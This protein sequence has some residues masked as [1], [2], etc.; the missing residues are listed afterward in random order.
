[1]INLLDVESALTEVGYRSRI[2]KF[3][4]TTLLFEDDSILGFV[5][6]F[7]TVEQLLENWKLKQNQFVS[8]MTVEL[9]RSATKS[10]NC[11][12]VFLTREEVDTHQR[13][14]L[15]DIEEDLS[16]TRKLVGDGLLTT[17]DIR[18]VLLPILPIQ[19][20][21]SSTHLGSQ[22]LS[23]RLQAWPRAALSALEGDGTPIDLVE[24]LF[25]DQ[26]W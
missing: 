14:L 19:N 3:D 24:F 22:S 15:S 18:R 2:A 1:M 6:L 4:P 8:R 11:Y 21:T 12:A 23:S 16:L 13:A 25:E 7:D 17:R 10:W 5:S 20:R 26:P 9:R